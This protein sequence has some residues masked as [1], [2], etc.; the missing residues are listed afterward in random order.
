[1]VYAMSTARV[2]RITVMVGGSYG[3]GNYGMCGRGFWPDFLFAWPTAEVATMSA[4]ICTNILVELR[5]NSVSEKP[6]TDE[7]LKKIE[8]RTR[9]MFDE[10]NDPYYATSRLWDDGLIDPVDTRDV[11]GLCLAVSFNR[12]ELEDPWPV[13]RM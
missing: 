4:E 7:E 10:Q 9:A 8:A 11:L 3:A 6:A 13:Y 5:K 2:P 12:P 1:M